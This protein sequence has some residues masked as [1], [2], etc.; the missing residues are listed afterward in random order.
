MVNESRVI[1]QR[2]WYIYTLQICIN[3]DKHDLEIRELSKQTV[4]IRIT[5]PCNE[6]PLTTHFYIEKVGFTRVYMFFLF[7]L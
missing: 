7:L 6:H 3:S 4:D 5:C 1:T 2:S